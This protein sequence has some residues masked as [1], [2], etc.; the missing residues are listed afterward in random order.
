MRDRPQIRAL[1]I[2]SR[3]VLT[4]VSNDTVTGLL[5]SGFPGNG[6]FGYGTIGLQ[7]TRVVTI[8]DGGYGIAR[9]VSSRTLF[10]NDTAIGSDEARFYAGTHRRPTRRCATIR[11]SATNSASSS[12]TPGRSWS[13]A[14]YVNA[15]CQLVA[16]RSGHP[17]RRAADQASR[18]PARRCHARQRIG[19]RSAR[20]VRRAGLARRPFGVRSR[21][22][23]W[24]R[25][26]AT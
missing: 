7:V 15:N 9:F 20:E 8:N 6:V 4:P 2:F 25:E 5:V 3:Y 13:P 14:N 24:L 16:E 11:R 19:P 17:V 22:I 23:G 18:A 21:E 12:G 10:A 1:S 26:D